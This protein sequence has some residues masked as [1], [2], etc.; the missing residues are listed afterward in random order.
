MR[1]EDTPPRLLRKRWA[2]RR[3]LV[4]RNAETIDSGQTVA[5]NLEWLLKHILS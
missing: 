1:T 3:F 5:C 2:A 4:T